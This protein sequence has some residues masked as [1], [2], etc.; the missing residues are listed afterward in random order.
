[1]PRFRHPPGPPQRWMTCSLPEFRSDI[2][3]FFTTCAR[4][5]GDICSFRLGHLK[6]IL[7]NHP[8]LIE[9]VLVKNNR[10][11]AKHYGV[12]FARPVLGDGL[13]TSDGEHWRR[14]RQL[15]APAF[16]S[17]RVATYGANMVD[18]IVR[19]IDTWQDGQVRDVH[20][21]MMQLA[22]DIV[23][24]SLFGADIH[25][26][27]A[28][29]VALRSAIA[30][31]AARSTSTIPLPA[32]VPTPDNLRLRTAIR[33]LNQIVQ[34]IIEKRRADG[35]RRGDLLSTFIN[36]RDDDDGTAMTD[37]QLSDQVRTFL[38]TGHETT[39]L[40]LT[41]T[42]YLLARHPQAQAAL[43]LELQT[44]L[45]GRLPAVSDLPSLKYTGQVVT[46]AMRLYSPSFVIGRQARAG[47]E[48]GGYQISAGTTV[49]MSQ[50]LVHR[51]AR[52][53][54]LPEQFEPERWV[55]ERAKMLPKMAYFP[56]G[57]GPRACIAANFAMMECVL[58]LATI[59]QHWSFALSEPNRLVEPAPLFT[60]R[61][62]SAIEVVLARR[63]SRP[64]AGAGLGDGPSRM[65]TKGSTCAEPH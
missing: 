60:L 54:E 49:F 18:A 64:G 23:A 27:H 57:G 43:Q 65:E 52:Y 39:A 7:I 47:C 9:S 40:A 4:D 13:L 3:G 63:T 38:L 25:D 11:F 1:M 14:Q 2:L 55:T 53:Y 51:D 20:V 12:R 45:D 36:A 5:F 37:R 41:W 6:C 24:K 46:E 56:F 58:V 10:N 17:D 62:A 30:N 19:S 26:G 29:D 50:W 44:V 15:A 35:E 28:I 32:W 33:Q 8:E 21:D 59:A 16:H 48:L 34:R 31:F 61:P 22:L 42:W